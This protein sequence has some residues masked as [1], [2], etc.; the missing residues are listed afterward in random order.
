MTFFHNVLD[1]LLEGHQGCLKI[2]PSCFKVFLFVC[3]SSCLVSAFVLIC[4]KAKHVWGW[5]VSESLVN[6]SVTYRQLNPVKD[7]LF[8]VLLNC[9]LHH[10]SL[11][12]LLAWADENSSPVEYRVR[13]IDPYSHSKYNMFSTFQ[14]FPFLALPKLGTFHLGHSSLWNTFLYFVFALRTAG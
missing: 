12:V 14:P 13:A 8:Q 2:R 6:K 7:A 4:K 11:L 9:S 1:R 5:G 3:H 10:P